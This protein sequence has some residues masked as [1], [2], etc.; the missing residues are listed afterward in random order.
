V[1][2]LGRARHDPAQC[3]AVPGPGLRRKT[4][5]QPWPW[6]WSMRARAVPGP[7]PLK[8]RPWPL[9]GRRSRAWALALE[10]PA[11]V[12]FLKKKVI[13]KCIFFFKKKLFKKIYIICP[14][15]CDFIELT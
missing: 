4:Q 5:A 12:F 6:P 14:K 8:G 15:R 7:R 1:T 9:K 2:G 11:L 10:G 13:Q 3:R